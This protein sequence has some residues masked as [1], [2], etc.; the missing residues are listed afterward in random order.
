MTP[1]PPAAAVQAALRTTTERLAAEVASP[2]P[3]APAWTHFEWRIA[4]AVAVMHG[5]SGLLSA[6]LA[7]HGPPGWMDFL[8]E[9]HA[10]TAA[11]Q[12]RLIELR[13]RVNAAFAEDAIPAQA[14]KGAV[15]DAI[16]YR[17]GERPM[18]DLDVLVT[19][20]HAER[21][22]DALGRLGLHET[23]RT[24]KHRV[25][26]AQPGAAAAHFG[27]HADNPL[28]VELH[29]RICEPL[30]LHLTDIT[31]RVAGRDLHPGL[32]PYP[33]P[34]ALMAHLLLHAAGGMTWRTLRLIQLHDIALLAG[35]LAVRDWEELLADAPG[36]AWPPLSL[37]ARYYGALLP[38]PL[39]HA[40]HAAC[41][42]ILRH[43]SARQRLSDVSLSRLWIEPLPGIEWA[44]SVT[45]ALGFAA[46]RLVPSARTRAERR[47]SLAIEP[48]LREGDWGRLSQARRVLRVLGTRTPRPWPLH[49]VRAALALL[50]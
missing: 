15:L 34:A 13:E 27:E 12:V 30:P 8:R 9:Q 26:E 16:F 45:E 4:R 24:I 36:W 5:V 1:L 41:P 20:P 14:L 25:F 33:S 28:K 10:H 3:A 11:R 50:H 48:S 23:Q 22:A 47:S 38:Y 29:E 43:V 37:A 44:H 7:W 32:N 42:G 6:R 40:A 21:A 35:T 19:L 17:P 2:R 31:R 46:R 39:A 49:N 18:A